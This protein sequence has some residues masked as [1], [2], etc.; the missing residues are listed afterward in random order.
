M[1]LSFSKL[2]AVEFGDIKAT[3]V[4]TQELRLRIQQIKG[5]AID[6]T[7]SR[8]LLSSAFPSVKDA[9]SEFMKDNFSKNDYQRL[10]TYLT[11]GAAGLERLDNLTERAMEKAMVEEMREAK[12]AGDLNV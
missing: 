2:E 7:D 3:P 6:T 9:V 1:A 10:Q 11:Q 12:K 5:D 4:L 8:D